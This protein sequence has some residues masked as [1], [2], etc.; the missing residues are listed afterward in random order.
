M[1]MMHEES[2]LSQLTWLLLS[3]VGGGGLLHT[4]RLQRSNPF[5]AH[6]MIQALKPKHTMPPLSLHVHHKQGLNLKAWIRF[7]WASSV[8]LHY[9]LRGILWSINQSINVLFKVQSHHGNGLRT[10]VDNSINTLIKQSDTDITESTEIVR[11]KQQVTARID[12]NSEGGQQ[13]T[14]HS[15]LRIKTTLTWI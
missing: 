8:P 10:L 14:F 5:Q 4:E 9:T 13:V 2:A 15:A 3:S 7:L 11:G 6:Q 1:R 12:L